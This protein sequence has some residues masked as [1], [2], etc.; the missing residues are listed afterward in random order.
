M[1][2]NHNHPY[3]RDV[4][5][6]VGC[7]VPQQLGL[8]DGK[9]LH[10]EKEGIEGYNIVIKLNDSYLGIGDSFLFQGKDFHTREDVHSILAKSYRDKTAIVMEFVVADK[11]LGVHSLDF[12]TQVTQQGRNQH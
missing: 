9:V 12:V 6:K 1:T 7:K 2:T 10:E 3:F 5:E 8:W 11:A 4:M